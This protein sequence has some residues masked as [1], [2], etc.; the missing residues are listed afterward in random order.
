MSPRI[1]SNSSTARRALRIVV[2]IV[3]LGAQPAQAAEIVTL[4]TRANVTQSY[5]LMYDKAASAKAVALPFQLRA[6][7]SAVT[8]FCILRLSRL[9]RNGYKNPIQRLLQFRQRIGF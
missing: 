3:L 9:C 2:L 7:Q 8:S 1:V 4:V 5:L 6:M